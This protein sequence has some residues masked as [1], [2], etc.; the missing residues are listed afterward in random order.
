MC[1][2][3]TDAFNIKQDESSAVIKSLQPPPGFLFVSSAGL[4]RLLILGTE[5]TKLHFYNPDSKKDSISLL[6]RLLLSFQACR[7][8]FYLYPE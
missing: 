6:F 7:R 1:T 4:A 5:L 8:H 2:N 3:T